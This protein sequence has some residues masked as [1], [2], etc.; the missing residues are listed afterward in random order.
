MNISDYLEKEL[1]H[2]LKYTIDSYLSKNNNNM[3]HKDAGDQATI[4]YKLYKSELDADNHALKEIE[5]YLDACLRS[6]TQA[7]AFMKMVTEHTSA[8][9]G[10]IPTTKQ[11]YKSISSQDF[12]DHINGFSYTSIGDVGNLY[13]KLVLAM[14]Y[15]R[16][17]NPLHVVNFNELNESYGIAKK[18]SG[19]VQANLNTTEYSPHEDTPN[20]LSKILK[21]KEKEDY[22]TIYKEIMLINR[23]IRSREN[24]IEEKNMLLMNCIHEVYP[25]FHPSQEY[26][27]V[28]YMQTNFCNEHDGFKSKMYHLATVHLKSVYSFFISTIQRY[29][30]R[31][32][33]GFVKFMMSIFRFVLHLVNPL[34]IFNTFLSEWIPFGWTGKVVTT[35]AGMSVIELGVI[36]FNAYIEYVVERK[37]LQNMVFEEKVEVQ[38]TKAKKLLSKLALNV[39]DFIDYK[40]KIRDRFNEY[41]KVKSGNPLH[42]SQ[43]LREIH[44]MYEK[45]YPDQFKNLLLNNRSVVGDIDSDLV[46]WRSQKLLLEQK[47]NAILMHSMSSDK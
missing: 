7:K 22:E 9:F 43:L 40:S 47:R 27:F 29:M 41:Q 3:K 35:L 12:I 4:L 39:K 37:Y 8:V 11:I 26:D 44:A 25:S 32:G 31:F 38:N 42:A 46:H 15:M 34:T 18:L 10:L 20:I 16:A 24:E 21:N 33:L 17:K 13:I 36:F 2:Q 14:V 1:L 28:K 19:S 5:S 45:H 6:G 23:N 30:Y